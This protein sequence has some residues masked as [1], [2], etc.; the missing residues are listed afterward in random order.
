MGSGQST[1]QVSDD[2]FQLLADNLS[3]SLIPRRITSTGTGTS[4]SS[5]SI[6]PT[7][8]DNTNNSVNNNNTKMNQQQSLN[9]QQQQQQHIILSH[10]YKVQGG[11]YPVSGRMMRTYR[12]VQHNNGRNTTNNVNTTNNKIDASNSPQQQQHY[13]Q[14]A[15]VLKTGWILCRTSTNTVNA[16]DTSPGGLMTISE[17]EMILQEHSNE[18]QRIYE[19][20]KNQSHIVPFV[21]WFVGNDIK[22]LPLFSRNIPTSTNN[23]TTVVTTTNSTTPMISLLGMSQSQQPSGTSS[24]VKPI[25]MIRPYIYTTLADR[26]CN[27]P[28]LTTCEKLWITYQILQALIELHESNIV[29]GFLTTENIGLTSTGWVVL[30][31]IAS[32]KMTPNL[33]LPDNDPSEYLYYYQQQQ[34]YQFHHNNSSNYQQQQQQQN[35]NQSSS[36]QQQY[37]GVNT[38]NSTQTTSGGGNSMGMTTGVSGP[39]GV[40]S[41]GGGGGGGPNIGSAPSSNNS[42]TTNNNVGST[43]TANK[44]SNSSSE[45]RCYLAPERFHT[46]SSSSTSSVAVD[47][48]GG[49]GISSSTSAETSEISSL[50]N[51]SAAT[52]SKTTTTKKKLTPEMD[53]FS[54]GC[55]LIELFLNGER[56]FDLGELMEYRR[57]MASSTT[58]IP[59]FLQQRLNKIERS[60]IR[61]A[62][63]HMLNVNPYNRLSAQQYFNRLNES[64]QFASSFT[65]LTNLVQ[66]VTTIDTT[67]DI[68]S[69]NNNNNII[70]Q[71][72]VSN[73]GIIADV[74]QTL[75][76]IQHTKNHILDSSSTWIPPKCP[77]ARIA[78]AA[79]MYGKVIWECMGIRD[80]VGELYFTKVLGITLPSRSSASEVNETMNN[81]E[82]AT[83][84]ND[85]EEE[86]KKDDSTEALFRQVEAMLKDLDSLD[87]NNDSKDFSC[88]GKEDDMKAESNTNEGTKED[89]LITVER[90]SMCQNS[91]L[92]YL[93]LI[94][95]TIRH[96]QRPSTKVV[97]LQLI[98]R[99]A[100]YCNNDEARLQRIVPVTI[101]LLTEDHDPVVRGWAVRV[102][103]N[104]VSIIQA[105]PPSDS[106]L[107]QQYIFKRVANMISDQSLVVRIAFTRCIAT[108]AETAHRFLD[109]THAVRLYEA[110]G[111]SG[112][113]HIGQ[114]SNVFDDDVARLLDNQSRSSSR[115]SLAD[116]TTDNN[117]VNDASVEPESSYAARKAFI[118]TSSYSLELSALHET[119]SRWVVHIATDQSEHSSLQ[120][121]AMLADLGKLCIFFGLDG[122]MSFVLPH[123]LAFLNEKKD[124][125]LR[126]ELFEHLPSVCHIIGRASTEE[127]VL[128]CV[129]IGLVDAENR[130]ICSSL[131]CLRQLVEMG[132][133]SRAA[134]FGSDL[135]YVDGRTTN[136]KKQS[137][138]FLRKYGVLLLFPADDVRQKAIEAYVTIANAVG[139]P[140]I[141]V[142]IIPDLKPFFRYLPQ[143]IHLTTVQ[144]MQKCLHS[145]WPR[146]S[147]DA[148][149]K[150]TAQSD[151]NLFIPGS[152]TKIGVAISDGSDPAIETIRREQ[153]NESESKNQTIQQ[154][155]PFTAIFQEYV[156]LLAKRGMDSLSKNSDKSTSSRLAN[157]IEGPLRLAQSIMFPRQNGNFYKSTL[158]DWYCSLREKT[159]SNKSQVSAE[160]L[161]KTISTLGN[162][163][164]LS[165][166]GPVEGITTTN[167]VDAA[168]HVPSNGLTEES[169]KS[170]EAVRIESAFRGEWSSE[171]LLDPD[172]AETM[173]LISKLKA[174]GVPPLP[175]SLGELGVVP[176]KRMVAP[177][178]E[179]TFSVDSKPRVKGLLASSLPTSSGH[180][181]P[182]VRLA[183]SK[184]QFFFV[185][186][187][188]DGTCRVWDIPQ[189]EDSVGVLESNIK[190]SGHIQDSPTRINDVAMLEGTHSI[191]S[192]ASDGSVHVWR[193]DMVHSENQVTTQ[194]TQRLRRDR[195]RVSGTSSIRKADSN[196][197]EVL[198]ISHF[199]TSAASIIAFATQKGVVHSWDLRCAKEPFVL[200]HSPDL[201]YLSSMA[202]GTDQHWMVTGTSKGFLTLWDIRFQQPVKLWLHS[203]QSPI[204]RLATSYVVPPQFWH[205]PQHSDGPRPFV[206][207]SSG[208]NE[209]SM[210][211]ATTGTCSECF[212][213]VSMGD[214]RNL[215]GVV[216]ETPRLIETP[217]ATKTNSTNTV[218]P[219]NQ[220]LMLRHVT[221]MATINCIVG[222]IGGNSNS[223]IVTGGSDCAIRFWDFSRPSNCY[224]ICGRSTQLQPKPSYERVDFDSKRRLMLCREP[225]STGMSHDS[226]KFHSPK[227]FHGHQK[228][229][230]HHTDSVQDIKI[231]NNSTVVS[232]SRDCTV[233]VWR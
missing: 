232:C 174:L 54:L 43:T 41:I 59:T 15:A 206:F 171:T 9:Q 208:S 62:C 123:I 99:I 38:S 65:V 225:V 64:N 49:G 141:E 222:S 69:S 35:Y 56:C 52:N 221:P 21:S 186:G 73:D 142:L 103:T 167:I 4:S 40:G 88:E 202:I 170:S 113:D 188:H 63:K 157:G 183:M 90:S 87:N 109:I 61:A 150:S 178:K 213:T 143:P 135:L 152:W 67:Q 26:L 96:V 181:A 212:R 228:N 101:S 68:V 106:K 1:L 117:S 207:V 129:E 24:Y 187:S 5:S 204:T 97:A 71:V 104:T 168:D 78:V 149:L 28:W 76:T 70:N 50:T 201:G 92:I 219:S 159:E 86:E 163:Y 233:K 12:I 77:D 84:N 194:A 39:S 102:L 119:V 91:I 230:H 200:R 156:Q 169:L 120:K 223:Y 110:V 55:V 210:F 216:E 83:S 172:I 155:E 13:P 127:F 100:K 175:P 115:G 108:L 215:S 125:E 161:I 105:F 217:I 37:G 145:P 79:S 203:R 98:D 153:D 80:K 42:R 72:E 29:H 19:I 25:Y 197:G 58:I 220:L 6:L 189:I 134:V 131:S 198:T 227:I 124:W 16:T 118:V 164:G 144:G 128:P 27:R 229:E 177:L 162:V 173:L 226:T 121:R 112:N 114:Q 147:Y 136:S 81:N 133:L 66:S 32:Y 31:D 75:T 193:V 224:V 8:N 160:T 140:D 116:Q 191:V 180:T 158:P 22:T 190:Y 166:L 11:L 53:I 146:K 93:Q 46:P 218:K 195:S 47:S 214:N 74:Q 34:T 139:S 179:P 36:E 130:V 95:S 82:K 7:N 111:N 199:N 205:L 184:D 30:M 211:D 2:G 44:T 185:S 94:L 126:A 48:G 17:E 107:F 192:G 3:G 33:L 151:P 10:Y 148:L 138:S 231:I 18:L 20:C 60:N 23:N 209:C 45:K 196:E 85:D 154:K 132:L 165:I 57:T 137:Y 89:D 182:V 14:S 122:V 51:P 176:L